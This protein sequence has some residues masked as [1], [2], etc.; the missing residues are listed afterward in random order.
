VGAAPSTLRY[1]EGA[2]VSMPSIASMT[3]YF[4]ADGMTP[5]GTVTVECRS[6][7]SRFL[8][9]TLRLDDT[10][11]FAEPAIRERLQKRLTR[12]KVE[13]RMSLSADESALPAQINESALKRLLELQSAVLRHSP[14]AAELSVSE[15]LE[16]P[17][18]A[19]TA[20]TD[21][22]ELLQ[23]VLAVLDKTLD[24]FIAA[25]ER[26][27]AALAKVINGYMDKMTSVVEEVRAAIPQILAQL[28]AKLAA[29]LED[30]LSQT[31]TQQGTLTKEE[32]TE[33]IRQEV[34]LYAM[35]MDVD[36]EMNRLTTHIAE[37]RRLLAAGGAVGRKLDFMAQEM[38]REA[39]TLGSKAAA[40]E[41]T[42]A[43]LSL[44]ITIDQ[45]REQIQNLE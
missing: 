24:G 37:V 19:H 39:N 15:I 12:G 5:A 26:E 20:Q 7:N 40:I 31:L 16:M 28:Q 22:D 8:D 41:M 4:A 29:R 11:R 27:G 34:T 23:A 14:E 3:G 1:S 32:I 35:R 17:G 43:S 6:V 25:R 30:A 18:I 45:M 42:Q 44:K 21:K 2:K 38:N 10:L 33:R 36:E 13:V 9:L